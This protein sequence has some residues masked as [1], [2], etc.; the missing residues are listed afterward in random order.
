MSSRRRRQ[1]HIRDPVPTL[2]CGTAGS[3]IC[4]LACL[5]GMTEM[6]AACLSGMTEMR[7]ACLSGMTEMR[8]ACLAGMTT[9]CVLGRDD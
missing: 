4:A 6:R 9:K 8:A 7:A 3:R 2:Y 5:S 1:P